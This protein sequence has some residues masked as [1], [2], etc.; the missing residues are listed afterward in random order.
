M[1]FINNQQAEILEFHTFS[2]DLVR[3]DQYIDIS[4]RQLFQDTACIFCRT[5]TTQV[6]HLTGHAF[7][8]LAE[9]LIVL[10][11][12]YSRRNEYGHLFVVRHSLEGSPHSNFG[13]AEAHI[14]TN[15]TIHRTITFH[16]CLHVL[17]CL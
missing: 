9:G 13:L 5:G 8:T 1:L 17:S 7:Q 3:T 2:N 16:V 15:Q 6:I 12:Q 10:I 11:G 14:T 4:V